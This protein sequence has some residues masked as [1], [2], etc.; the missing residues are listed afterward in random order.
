MHLQF[1]QGIIG[2]DDEDDEEEEEDDGEEGTPRLARPLA[3]AQ[4]LWPCCSCGRTLARL[5]AFHARATEEEAE[6]EEV[7]EGGEEDE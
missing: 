4:P 3:S 2:F 5:S 6:G 1:L 7:E